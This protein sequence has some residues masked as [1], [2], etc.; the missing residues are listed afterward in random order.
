MKIIFIDSLRDGGTV[1]ISTEDGE[2]YFDGALDSKTKGKFFQMGSN[3]ENIEEYESKLLDF[4]N[5]N[6]YE[7]YLKIISRLKNNG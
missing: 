4:M 3:V 1:E 5:L 6:G 2:F 7:R